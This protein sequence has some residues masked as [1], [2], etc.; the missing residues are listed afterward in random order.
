MSMRSALCGKRFDTASACHHPMFIVWLQA[1]RS[2][3]TYFTVKVAGV[4]VEAVC[5]LYVALA[6]TV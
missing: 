4:P 5:E 2:L 6:V 1:V 3:V